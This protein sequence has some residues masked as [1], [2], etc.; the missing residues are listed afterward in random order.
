[1]NVIYY[2]IN[3]IGDSSV[4]PYPRPC[5]FARDTNREWCSTVILSMRVSYFQSREQISRSRSRRCGLPG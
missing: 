4:N 3:K 5:L 2:K 1:M